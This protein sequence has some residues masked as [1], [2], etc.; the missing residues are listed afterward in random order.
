MTEP[1][2]PTIRDEAIAW[3]VRLQAGGAEDWDAFMAWLEADPARSAA[4]DEVKF[5]DAAITAAKT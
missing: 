3:H 4:Y 5:A 1:R 2:L